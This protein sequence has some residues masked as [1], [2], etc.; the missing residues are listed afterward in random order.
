[1]RRALLILVVL[2]ASAWSCGR[3]EWAIPRSGGSACMCSMVCACDMSQNEET[4]KERDRCRDACSCDRC[5][6]EHREKSETS[7][8]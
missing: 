1:M 6:G 2:A 7:S 4:Q 3:P 8:P 5:P